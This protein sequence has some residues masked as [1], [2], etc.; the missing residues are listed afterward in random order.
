MKARKAMVP[1]G[2][3]DIHEEMEMNTSEAE[4]LLES[5][6]WSLFAGY[7][8]KNLEGKS[9][10]DIYEEYKVAV[11]KRKKISSVFFA[12]LTW[13]S[14]IVLAIV[15]LY[16]YH[17]TCSELVIV[18]GIIGL[19]L[20]YYF[21]IS[22]PMDKAWKYNRI[23]AKCEE[24]FNEFEQS[25]KAIDLQGV[26]TKHVHTDLSTHYALVVSAAILLEVEKKFKE[27][28]LNESE[29][30]C[31]VLE[32]GN[33]EVRCRN[34]FEKSLKGAEKFGLY[35]NKKNYLKKQ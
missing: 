24:G 4:N 8:M 10:R 27:T 25:V 18:F 9:L 12:F 1:K 13:I 35:F 6:S 3:V 16:L 30:T 2:G 15:C 11:A 21:T 28:R 17:F 32:A 23:I 34:E 26:L 19:A 22:Y 33:W 29:S 5:V 7:E 31:S 20:I 14:V